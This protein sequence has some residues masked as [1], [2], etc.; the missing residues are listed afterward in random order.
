MA[1]TM[2]I[3]K[4]LESPGTVRT[5][6]FPASVVAN[7]SPGLENGFLMGD[8]GLRRRVVVVACALAIGSS[9]PAAVG[10][11]DAA[12][13][14]A[15]VPGASLSGVVVNASTGVPIRGALVSIG[16]TSE[17]RSFLTG[18]DG[19][20][21]LRSAAPGKGRIEARK[22][23]YIPSYYGQTE[24]GDSPLLL[25]L[26]DGLKINGLV[27]KML[28]A[29][30]IS[31]V[32]LDSAGE[33][34]PFIVVTAARRGSNPAAMGTPSAATDRA[35]RYA[36]GG[37][38]AGEYVVTAGLPVMASGAMGPPLVRFSASQDDHVP[39]PITVG[40]GDVRRG[41][42][43]RLREPSSQ[44]GPRGCLISG[45]LLD[46]F[47]DPVDGSVLATLSNPPDD[48]TPSSMAVAVRTDALGRYCIT[49]L[50]DG[51]YLVRA[52][53]A[54]SV[55]EL[56]GPDGAGGDRAVT[57][58]LTF[59]PD[60]TRPSAA[61]PIFIAGSAERPDIDITVR[62]LPVSA[63]TL[64]FL[65]TG[66][67]LKPP[68]VV[69]SSDDN[70]QAAPTMRR[71][72]VDSA[73]RF[74]SV[75]A[76]DYVVVAH[77]EPVSEGDSPGLW[78]SANLVSDGVTP[79]EQTL[80]LQPGGRIAGRVVFDGTSPRP[81]RPAVWL[82]P[83]GLNRTAFGDLGWSGAGTINDDG[84]FVFDG[85]M[86]GRYVVRAADEKP[87]DGPR[88]SVSSVKQGGQEAAD[89]PITLLP[90][91]DSG[92]LLITLTDRPTEL[93][94]RLLDASGR[95]TSSERVVAF[96]VDQRYWWPASRRVQTAIPDPDGRYAFKD[97]PA[98]QY[99]VAAL[100]KRILHD[101]A[102]DLPALLSACT[103]VTLLTGERKTVEARAR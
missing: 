84:T 62:A 4:R 80:L 70:G 15:T 13:A 2:V 99:C 7:E 51:E 41:I 25:T 94:V 65:D 42:D 8:V 103:P 92:D 73:V 64:R 57:L 45:R 38:V 24:P 3:G 83:V 49:G 17:A 71:P 100:G 44:R 21:V 23:G 96:A 82:T 46:E 34:A 89:L 50:D 97:L 5:S 16:P 35:G 54:M 81:S 22:S 47:G 1:V 74:S 55:G 77:A 75:L 87:M 26:R 19:R 9:I 58:P 101:S 52:F 76:G 30:T 61:Q 14:P 68:R 102:S 60:V 20:F 93:A 59:Y 6:R 12:P 79:I 33:P 98:G 63:I 27:V 85:I 11:Q 36:I 86:P 56:R 40:A 31:G 32:I 72:D 53:T 66:V 18:L 67:A 43:L 78:T 90:R 48:P 69:L 39:T 10:E 28:P 29:A 88:W 95:P 91:G 37:L